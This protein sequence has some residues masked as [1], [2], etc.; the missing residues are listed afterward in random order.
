MHSSDSQVRADGKDG[1]GIQ[2]PLLDQAIEWLMKQSK[3]VSSVFQVS[4]LPMEF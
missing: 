4:T 1:C 3:M 2:E